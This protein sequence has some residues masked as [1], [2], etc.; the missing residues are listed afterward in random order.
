MSDI[1][2]LL[3]WNN[4]LQ[5]THYRREIKAKKRKKKRKEKK[6]LYI[7]RNPKG[8]ILTKTEANKETAVNNL[9]P[10]LYLARPLLAARKGQRWRGDNLTN[11]WSE[12]SIDR[13]FQ[14]RPSH[15]KNTGF[16]PHF[17]HI[18]TW[19]K[20]TAFL[21]SFL[22]SFLPFVSSPPP[23]FFIHVSRFAVV[24]AVALSLKLRP[25]PQRKRLS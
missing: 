4:S 14:F 25:F 12:L 6:S 21:P 5:W 15:I 22:S 9:L 17:L 8:Q 23:D 1:I 10:E 3:R 2:T 13:S 18:G 7:I 24:S 16:V 11:D 19:I 20:T